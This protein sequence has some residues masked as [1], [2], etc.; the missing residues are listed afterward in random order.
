M[1]RSNVMILFFISIIS[2]HII[3]DSS[4]IFDIHW[5]KSPLPLA[6]DDF[7][8]LNMTTSLGEKYTCLLPQKDSEHAVEN[9]AYKGP[10]AID[11]IEHLFNTGICSYRLDP[12]WTYEVCHGKYIRQYHE[13]LDGSRIKL[14]QFT[15]GK[16][17]NKEQEMVLRVLRENELRAGNNSSFALPVKQIEN[18]KLPYVEIT[19]TDG[20]PCE[21]H[22]RKLRESRVYYI[23]DLKGNH[24][25]Y[26]VKEIS[27]C[28]YEV[29]ILTPLLCAHPKYRPKITPTNVI[30][31]YALGK[32]S[33]L[34]FNLGKMYADRRRIMN[35]AFQGES[36]IEFLTYD[37]KP[38]P[39]SMIGVDSL[40]ISNF[41]SGKHC[42]SGGIGSWKYEF[43]YGK[44]LNQYSYG[45]LGLK[46]TVCLGKFNVNKHIDWIR[47]HPYKRPKPVKHRNYI[48]Q[49]YSDGCISNITG[50]PRQT[51]VKLKCIENSVNWTGLMMYLYEPNFGEYVFGIESPILCY[52]IPMANEDGLIFFKT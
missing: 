10:L 31:C 32:T 18:K 7:E 11:F 23:C 28:K 29:I 13:V 26:S 36:R 22:K 21:F 16:M 14:Q 40:M 5:S 46:S 52:V 30:T 6:Q 34:P 1:Y 45:I 49:F 42:I 4:K 39:Q 9:F 8:K 43:C 35:E 38:G 15:L 2:T 33:K 24:D 51:E 20:S 3:E 48:T 47:S 12:Y 19:M 37:K 41:L 50:K 17:G 44:Y 27:S 25:I